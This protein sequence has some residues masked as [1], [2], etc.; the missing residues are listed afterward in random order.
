V[1]ALQSYHE[2]TDTTM[3]FVM[4][5]QA[6]G[7]YRMVRP[8]GLKPQ[9]S[10]SV[11]FQENWRTYTLTGE[12]LMTAGVRVDLPGMWTT[13]IVYIEPLAP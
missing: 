3:I 9:G 5:P 7:N 6:T 11:R 12:Q 13:E 8:R 4:R 10:Y 1:D 2:A